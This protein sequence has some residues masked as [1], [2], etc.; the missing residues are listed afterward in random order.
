MSDELFA[1]IIL[2]NLCYV[3]PFHISEVMMKNEVILFQSKTGLLD[4][5]VEDWIMLYGY[6]G[7]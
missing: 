1:K 2:L 6:L 7:Y 4:L 5:N 3:F